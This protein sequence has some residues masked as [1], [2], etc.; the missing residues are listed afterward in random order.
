MR[1]GYSTSSNTSGLFNVDPMSMTMFLRCWMRQSRLVATFS[2]LP[3]V[4]S[5]SKTKHSFSS[6]GERRRKSA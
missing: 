2:G 3:P 6:V 5:R 1:D 4:K